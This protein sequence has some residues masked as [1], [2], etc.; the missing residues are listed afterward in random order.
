MG[1][2]AEIAQQTGVSASTV[3]RVL[4]GHVSKSLPTD[5]KDRI[6]EGGARLG[7]QPRTRARTTPANQGGK[8]AIIGMNSEE[9]DKNIP[10]FHNLTVG[11]QK[12]LSARGVSVD[13]FRV[14]WS[15]SI[16][17]YRDF[18]YC[19]KII[20]LGHNAEAAKFF[21]TTDCQVLFVAASP[22]PQR[23]PAVVVDHPGGTRLAIKHLQSLGYAQIGYFG[24]ADEPDDA[25]SRFCAFEYVLTKE[26]IYDPRFVDLGG[27]WTARSG[28][29]MAQNAVSTG[30]VARSYFVANDPMAIGAISGFTSC[31]LRVPE[32]VAIV[33]FDN[34]DMA[35]YT[36]PPLTTVDDRADQCAYLA[37]ELIMGGLGSTL[38]L[39]QLT[40]PTSL[41]VRETCGCLLQAVVKT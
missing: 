21:S 39:V 22:N 10:F 38:P 7:Y 12:E 2:L 5:V 3:F 17:S 8:V 34:I 40:V 6:L 13:D 15:D 1:I 36:Q 29:E 28:F 30:I 25:L 41:I 37:V 33:G 18:E 9:S 27:D 32:D 19:G 11:I 16:Q 35:L 24:H 31:G 20:V 26:R 23:F 4:N 14:V